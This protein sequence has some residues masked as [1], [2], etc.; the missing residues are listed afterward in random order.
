MARPREFDKTVALG[1]A[2]NVFWSR[3]YEATSLSDLLSAME[4]SKS[5]FY[6]TFGSKHDVFLATIEHY[7]KTISAQISGIADL[8]APARKLIEGMFEKAASRMTEKGGQRGCYLNNCAVDV[9]LRDPEA[10]KLIHSG[11]AIMENTFLSLIERGQQEGD[12]AAGKN[13]LSLARYLT[14][15]LNG[16]MVTGKFNPDRD[17]LSDIGKTSLMVLD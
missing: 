4:L 8:D 3:G 10:A 17:V 15:S 12:I 6:D 7:K 16:I 5:S 9:S 2:M 14:S 13:A 11:I 1:Q